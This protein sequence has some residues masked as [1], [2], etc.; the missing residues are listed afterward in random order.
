MRADRLTSRRMPA[1]HPLAHHGPGQ[2]PMRRHFTGLFRPDSGPDPGWPWRSRQISKP[3]SLR[4]R[5]RSVTLTFT[6][7][8][9]AHNT[10]RPDLARSP[11]EKA[12]ELHSDFVATQSVGNMSWGRGWPMWRAI[13]HPAHRW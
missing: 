8:S 13:A 5:R 4:T 1:R 11:V 2:S 12:P 10:V 3:G 6:S 9:D 7:C